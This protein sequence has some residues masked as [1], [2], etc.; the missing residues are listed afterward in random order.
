MRLVDA[1]ALMEHVYRDRFDSR[2]LIAEMVRNAPTVEP[3]RKTGRWIWN[4]DG[5][6]WGLGAW[7]C[8]ECRTKAETWWASDERYNPLMCSGG[9]FCGNCGAMMRTEVMKSETDRRGCAHG[10]FKVLVPGAGDMGD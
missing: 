5:M 6:D 7:C 1:D 10:L 2:E 4:P 9:K 3:E 8:S